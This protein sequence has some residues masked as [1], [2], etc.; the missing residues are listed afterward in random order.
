[1]VVLHRRG[2]VQGGQGVAG[3]DLKA[4]VGPT[5]V[6]VMAQAGDD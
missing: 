2:G 4:V 6:Q 1:M 5:M 3:L